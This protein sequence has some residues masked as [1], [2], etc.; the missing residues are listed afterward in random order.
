MFYS[1]KYKVD[2]IKQDPLAVSLEIYQSAASDLSYAFFGSI[3]S[4]ELAKLSMDWK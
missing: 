3:E 1:F 4:C 2:Y